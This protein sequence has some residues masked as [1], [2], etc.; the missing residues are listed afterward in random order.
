MLLLTAAA[1]LTA[2]AT[3]EAR[4]ISSHQG[5]PGRNAQPGVGTVGSVD[6]EPN[7]ESLLPSASA[8][9]AGESRWQRRGALL[10]A[11]LR[12]AGS[13]TQAGHE[14]AARADPLLPGGSGRGGPLRGPGRS[15][16]SRE[17]RVLRSLPQFSSQSGDFLGAVCVPLDAVVSVLVPG[18]WAASP[19][20]CAG[21]IPRVIATVVTAK[22]SLGL[23]HYAVALARLAN[24]S[25]ASAECYE[26]LVFAADPR[27]NS[28]QR[29]VF[30]PDADMPAYPVPLSPLFTPLDSATCPYTAE[31]AGELLVDCIFGYAEG[32]MGGMGGTHY[33]VT[34]ASDDAL[35]PAPGTLR[36][37]VMTYSPVWITFRRNM[38]IVLQDMLYLNS[39]TTLDGRGAEVTLTR[40]QITLFNV[41]NV[42]IHNLIIRD[43]EGDHDAIHI[44][45]NTTRVWVDH[46]RISNA[47]RGLVDVV[48]GSTF[49]TISHNR[50]HNRYVLNGTKPEQGYVMLLG[51]SDTDRELD[52]QV[53]VFGNWFDSS[54]QRQ[55]HCRWG[56]CHVVNNVY[57]DWTFYCLGGRVHGHI[58]SEHNVFLPGNATREVTPWFNGALTT[59]GFDLTPT[60]LSFGDALHDNATLHEF[61][62]GPAFE[63]PYILP[64]RSGDVSGRGGHG[65]L[66][67]GNQQGLLAMHQPEPTYT[68]PAALGRLFYKVLPKVLQ[69]NL[70]SA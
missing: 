42:I 2:C 40:S 23:G 41:T 9:P 59:P 43:I 36:Y 26:A 65:Q 44:R 29:V 27:L 67:P 8:G 16:S 45:E 63:V 24:A 7:A 31:G 68:V 66:S 49:V 51:E 14:E 30:T 6:P 54:H 52:L 37:G 56:N 60:I 62:N 19:P 53:T 12:G 33:V 47:S 32:N 34:N 10:A 35:L 61:R 38:T 15:S 5:V 20:A 58:R 25:A 50:L 57:T 39:F 70:E 4:T 22:G 1:I 46:N 28:S 48:Y 18:G 21:G 55:P 17:E 3:C 11:A 13:R 64:V 69:V